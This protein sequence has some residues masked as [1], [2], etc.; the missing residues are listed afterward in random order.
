MWRQAVKK[1][2]CVAG[3]LCGIVLLCVTG[4]YADEKADK[5]AECISALS[6]TQ[7]YIEFYYM[8]TGIYPKSLSELERIFNEEEENPSKKLIFP[9]DPAT[10]KPFVYATAKDF[11]SYTLSC[12]D[13]SPYG[14]EKLSVSAVDWGWMNVV[15]QEKRRMAFAQFCKFNIEFLA[16]AVK[17]YN[18]AEKKIPADVKAL[19]PKYIKGMP[20]CPTC[21]K[22]YIYKSEGDGY[23]VTCPDPKEHGFKVFLFKSHE[24]FKAEPIESE[25]KEVNTP[26]KENKPLK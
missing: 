17:K 6:K 26:I 24:G 8:E 25:E 10:G 4:L 12:P 2:V 9:R 19:V 3:L 23:S 13:P 22:E 7:T 11:L 20:T 5:L 15:A 14:L 18:E 16:A 21:G 1:A